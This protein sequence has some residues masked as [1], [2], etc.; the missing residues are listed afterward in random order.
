MINY[1]L[2]MNSFLPTRLEES[3]RGSNDWLVEGYWRMEILRFV[4]QSLHLAGLCSVGHLTCSE[5]IREG[6]CSQVGFVVG[7]TVLTACQWLETWWMKWATPNPGI[8][9]SLCCDHRMTE[10]QWKWHDVLTTY[11]RKSHISIDEFHLL[12]PWCIL[13]DEATERSVC[14]K[15]RGLGRCYD[16]C[17]F[18]SEVTRADVSLTHH[19]LAY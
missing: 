19:S 7:A 15:L 14:T 6:N 8:K 12:P 18:W 5:G 13:D 9:V 17:F 1:S 2:R 16:I 11:S 3:P 4:I 10:G